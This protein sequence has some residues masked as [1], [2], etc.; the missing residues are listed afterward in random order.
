[1][2]NTFL[3]HLGTLVS[4]ESN[5]LQFNT[6]RVIILS[7][8]ELNSK[9]ETLMDVLEKSEALEQES[10]ILLNKAL[11]A[12]YGSESEALLNGDFDMTAKI[13]HQLIDLFPNELS[14]EFK[15]AEC[16]YLS[17][18]TEAELADVFLPALAKDKENKYSVGAEIFEYLQESRFADQ[19]NALLDKKHE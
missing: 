13:Y 12:Q 2:N 5:S 16:L 11:M 17:G 9:L 3:Y 1:M 14:F 18:C 15:L 19:L 7:D 4:I 8:M 10:V 6:L